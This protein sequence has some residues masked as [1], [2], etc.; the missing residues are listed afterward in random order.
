MKKFFLGLVFVVWAWAHAVSALEAPPPVQWAH[1]IGGGSSDITYG[2]ATDPAGN[3]YVTG[4]FSDTNTLGAINLVSSGLTDVFLAKYSP[5]GSL[6]WVRQA[7]GTS[8]DE[9]H[10]IAVDGTNAVY[11]TGLFQ[12][13]AAFGAVGLNSNGQSDVF[14]AKYDLSGNLLWA[15]RAG[16]KDYDEAHAIALDIAGNIYLAGT[17]DANASFGSVS[18]INNSKSSDIF[19]AKANPQGTFLWARNAGGGAEDDARSI[20]VDS[21]A[22][23]FVTG[24]F[25]E[26]ATFGSTSLTSQGGTSRDAFLA[27]YSSDGTFAWVRPAGGAGEDEGNGVTVDAVG[28]VLVTGSFF[29]PASFGTNNLTGDGTD[30]FVAKYD[31]AGN[32]RWARRAGGNDSIY[33]DAGLAIRT[34]AGGNAYVTGFISGLGNFG[35]TNLATSG[36]DDVFVAKYDPAGALLWA[37]KAGGRNI[38]IGYA[39]A[40][41]GTDRVCV[42]GFFYDKADFDETTLESSGFED[43]FIMQLAA[44]PAPSLNIQLSGSDILLSWPDWA[45]GFILESTDDLSN[46]ASWVTEPTVT[47]SVILPA[48]G[49]VK[50]FRLQRP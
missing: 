19:V 14:V 48:S 9:G 13:A 15:V 4:A 41:S 38:D 11:V 33:G 21:D 24:Y 47:N 8:Y 45:T 40:L 27:K 25:A 29:G 39:L 30:I 26:T 22:N 32:V 5:A 10:G 43:A 42:G 20:A 18:L 1:K 12:G 23:V 34:D 49:P 37:R 6:L 16:G 50:Y 3:V 44:L 31:S 36:F 28:N 17:F 7:G 2:V 46:P 35:S